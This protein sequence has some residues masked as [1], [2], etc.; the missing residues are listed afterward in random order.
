LESITEHIRSNG[1]S[2]DLLAKDGR[3]HN[4]ISV[5]FLEGPIAVQKLREDLEPFLTPKQP[6]EDTALEAIQRTLEAMLAA[7]QET[8]ARLSAVEA[9]IKS[10]LER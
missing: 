6:G 8:N 7:S 10:L 5:G 2:S 1:D 9:A 4:G 3:G